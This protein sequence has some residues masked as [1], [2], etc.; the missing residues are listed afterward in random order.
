MGQVTITASQ[1]GNDG[2]KPAASVDQVLTISK[3]SITLSL[4]A[5][6]AI[7]KVYDTYTGISLAGANYQLKDVEEGDDVSVTGEASFENNKAGENKTINV[8][9]F[10]L[11]GESASNYTLTTATAE[12]KGAIEP[13]KITV[14]LQASPL[15]SKTYNGSDAANL[16]SGN[17]ILNGVLGEDEVTI[18]S[19]KA[20]YS[21]KKAGVEKEITVTDFVLGGEQKNNYTIKN[22]SAV[23]IGDIKVKDITASLAGG[24]T[25]PPRAIEILAAMRSGATD[26]G[27]P[28]WDPVYG[29]GRID[30]PGNPR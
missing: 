17:F 24:R 16:S 7:S 5:T 9:N 8:N 19:A 10:V 23:T 15:I 3:K 27:D 21:D 14:N 11:G 29:W 1:P 6:P 20:V 2:Y 30:L 28:G 26:L 25:L 13:A 18:A 4:N 12:V 22:S